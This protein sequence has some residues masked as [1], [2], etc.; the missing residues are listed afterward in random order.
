MIIPAAVAAPAAVIPFFRNA[1]R[2]FFDTSLPISFI[3]GLLFA[4]SLDLGSGLS[5]KET[6]IGCIC[7][8]QRGQP[9]H[10]CP[11]DEKTRIAGA[12]LAK[13]GHKSLFIRFFVSPPTE[14]PPRNPLAHKSRLNWR[15]RA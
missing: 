9:V 5:E 7:P 6:E 14:N 11:F 13:S 3:S 4:Y 8:R 2:L 1:R 10:D 12:C 15:T